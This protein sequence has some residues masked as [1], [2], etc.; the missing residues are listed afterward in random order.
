MKD[1]DVGGLAGLLEPRGNIWVYKPQ[2]T[3]R[4]QTLGAVTTLGKQ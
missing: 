4:D 1:G 3:G 2:I